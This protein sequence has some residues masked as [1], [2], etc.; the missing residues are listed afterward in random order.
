MEKEIVLKLN[1]WALHSTEWDA[2][3]STSWC[4]NWIFYIWR[5]LT[6]AGLF[7]TV[8]ETW[9]LGFCSLIMRAC[10]CNCRKRWR[11]A[12]LDIVFTL[13]QG[14]DNV[15]MKVS[16]TFLWFLFKLFSI[17]TQ[18][19]SHK[20]FVQVVLLRSVWN[21]CK[22]WFDVMWWFFSPPVCILEAECLPFWM[23]RSF[24]YYWYILYLEINSSSSRF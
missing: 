21:R 24:L 9:H 12:K 20:T 19:S 18:Y 10:L 23:F 3:S 7:T 13:L 17:C 4:G 22:P 11:T 2:G 16:P 6:P 5:C 14:D 15:Y 8:S 1:P